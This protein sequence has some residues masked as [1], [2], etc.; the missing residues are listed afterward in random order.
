MVALLLYVFVSP[1]AAV[2]C[3][4][5][6]LLRSLIAAGFVC[7]IVWSA[8]MATIKLDSTAGIWGYQAILGAALALVL[9][10]VVAS[11]QLSAPAELM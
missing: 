10:A 7:F 8:L 6:K 4:R 2:I 9:N 11:A 3:H 5:F 1:L